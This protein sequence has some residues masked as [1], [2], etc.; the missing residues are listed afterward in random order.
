MTRA[1]RRRVA[2]RAKCETAAGRA[3]S[4]EGREV[5]VT[6]PLRWQPT[7]RRADQPD[8]GLVLGGPA[9]AIFVALRTLCQPGQ[10]VQGLLVAFHRARPSPNPTAHLNHEGQSATDHQDDEQ[11]LHMCSL[12]RSSAPPPGYGTRGPFWW[13]RLPSGQMARRDTYEKGLCENVGTDR[14]GRHWAAQALG[15]LVLGTLWAR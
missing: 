4:T 11:R 3:S 8:M 9:E 7:D 2:V 13:L 5:E 12:R 14:A 6:Q 15:T 10:R 1:T